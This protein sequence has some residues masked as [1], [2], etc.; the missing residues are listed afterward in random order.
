M[1]TNDT[2]RAACVVF[3]RRVAKILP[4]SLPVRLIDGMIGDG[5]IAKHYATSAAAQ[6]TSAA[7]AIAR[8]EHRTPRMRSE[9]AAMVTFLRSRW[10]AA[11]V[12]ATCVK[13]GD[14]LKRGG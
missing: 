10:G 13:R 3:L 2:E 9:R 4:T 11:R 1:K 8:G 5:V 14:H 6:V 12:I 7:N